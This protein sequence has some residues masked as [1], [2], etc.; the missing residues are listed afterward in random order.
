VRIASIYHT[1]R[2]FPEVQAQIKAMKAKGYRGQ[3]AV[4]MGIERAL[5][6]HP[7][8]QG[9]ASL[10]SRRLAGDYVTMSGSEK[11]ARDLIPFYLWNRHILKHTGNMFLEHPG[12]IATGA[13]LGDMG[14]QET[15]KLVGELPDFLKGAIPLAALGFGDHTGRMNLLSTASLNPYATVGDLADSVAAWTTGGAGRRGAALSQANPFVVGA[16]ESVFQTSALTGV[17]SPRHG[18]VIEDVLGRTLS[19]FPYVRAGKIFS[20][21]DRFQTPK[22]NDLLF[23][24]TKTT[25]ISSLLGVP[26]KDTSRKRSE[27]LTAQL[28]GKTKKGGLG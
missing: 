28:D 19:Q 26:I 12:R 24:Q 17:P 3:R 9:E 7:S 18:G 4:D 2:G 5:E 13:K 8:L 15:E 25:A 6:K 16:A 27:E 21:G 14:L 1:L 23:G 22:G 10:Q 11:W 20:D